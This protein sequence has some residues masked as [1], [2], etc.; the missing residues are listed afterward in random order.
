MAEST[1]V[2]INSLELTS[3]PPFPEPQS[4]HLPHD[5]EA[6]APQVVPVNHEEKENL[7][8]VIQ[9]DVCGV[10]SQSEYIGVFC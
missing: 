5:K 3:A 4:P 9:S 6:E 7:E 8:K 10:P 2:N 1:A